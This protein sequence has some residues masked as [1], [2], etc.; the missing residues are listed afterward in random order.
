MLLECPGAMQACREVQLWDTIDR[1]LCKNY[2]MDVLIFSLLDLLPSTQKELIVMIMWS[3]WKRRNLKLLQQQNETSL[4]VVEHARHLLDDWQAAQGVR[5]HR[6][7]D[8]ST[9]SSGSNSGHVI[10]WTKHTY[11]MYKCNIDASFSSSLNMLSID[12]CLRDD[13]GEFFLAKTD[14]F[15]PLCDVDVGEVVGL[16]TT[17]QCGRIFNLCRLCF[18]LQDCCRSL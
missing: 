3:L 13:H 12:I 8:C 11:G 5:S 17:L 16:H 10:E 9:H 18:G 6:A 14:C 4:Q 15:S 1:T 7:T 2:N